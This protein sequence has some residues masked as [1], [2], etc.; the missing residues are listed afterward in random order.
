MGFWRNLDRSIDQFLDFKPDAYRAEIAGLEE[1]QLRG[2]HKRIQRKLVGAGT[3]TAIGIGAAIPSGGLSLLGSL[4]GGRRISVNQ[5]RCDII[6]ALLRERGWRGHDFQLK[7]LIKGAAPS[8]FAIVLAP[9]ADHVADHAINHATTA[10]A[11]HGADQVANSASAAAVQHSAATAGTAFAVH[12]GAEAAIR[13][14]TNY[15]LN[16]R[17]RAITAQKTSNSQKIPNPQ[18]ISK[19]SVTGVTK[20]STSGSG[21]HRMSSSTKT[22]TKTRS[23]SAPQAGGFIRTVTRIALVL[24]PSIICSTLGKEPM[25]I[26][27]ALI[28]A[29]M[30]P[31]N[32]AGS[33]LLMFFLALPLIHNFAGMQALWGVSIA[34]AIVGILNQHSLY[35]YYKLLRLVKTVIYGSIGILV[36]VISGYVLRDAI[37]AYFS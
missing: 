15:G 1:E 21:K 9:G 17:T 27:S 11:H 12:H 10:A 25:W 32:S 19:Y 7:D 14:G 24:L 35:W 31:L 2:L 13:I 16:G 8:A 33:T 36:A 23:T 34:S 28:F 29:I 26:A 3:Q 30:G 37:T 6:E 20:P 22:T 5:Q 4:V 18:T